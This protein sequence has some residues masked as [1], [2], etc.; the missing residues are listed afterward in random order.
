MDLHHRRIQVLNYEKNYWFCNFISRY[1]HGDLFLLKLL[2]NEMK[3]WYYITLKQYVLLAEISVPRTALNKKGLAY[4]KGITFS[5]L[6]K[7]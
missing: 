5:F 7:V 6:G 1:F 4:F 2:A 3:Y